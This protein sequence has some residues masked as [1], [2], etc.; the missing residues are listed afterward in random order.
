MKQKFDKYWREYSVV[1][2]LGA[3]LDPRMNFKF[4][5]FCF[6][7]LDP[8]SCGEKLAKI[9]RNLSKLFREYNKSKRQQSSSS[10]SGVEFP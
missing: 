6:N 7:K 1:L 9:K 4:L 3:V 5:R 2:A 8:F 10:S